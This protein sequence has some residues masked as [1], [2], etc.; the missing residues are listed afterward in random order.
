MW[1]KSFERNN[2]IDVQN[3][4][5]QMATSVI[6]FDERFRLARKLHMVCVR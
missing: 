2:L 5:T 4:L 1:A 3:L 6:E